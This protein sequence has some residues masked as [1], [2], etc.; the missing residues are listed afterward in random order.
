[1]HL[2]LHY[3]ASPASPLGFNLM[4]LDEHSL[5]SFDLI[6]SFSDVILRVPIHTA[7][8]T[9]HQSVS[10]C[11]QKALLVYMKACALIHTWLWP[12]TFFRTY[13]PGLTHRYLLKCATYVKPLAIHV[14]GCLRLATHYLHPVPFS[15]IL[16]VKESLKSQPAEHNGMKL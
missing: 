3:Q 9:C 7:K 16:W 8:T 6:S 12:I 1:M 11:T 5:F 15:S 13:C 10:M 14:S 2:T 4:D